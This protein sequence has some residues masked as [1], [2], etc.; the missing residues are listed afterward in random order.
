M[1]DL[2]PTPDSTGDT[3]VVPSRGSTYSTPGWVKVFGIIVLVLILLAGIVLLTGLGGDHGP[4]RHTP[5]GDGGS[6]TPL[7]SVIQ[8]QALSRGDLVSHPPPS[9]I[10][11]NH[12]KTGG[13]FSGHTPVSG[14]TEQGVQQL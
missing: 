7:S 3:R 12:G 2:T 1:A 8:D 11:E 14:V 9:S 10:R 4:G 6:Q 13:D 5:S